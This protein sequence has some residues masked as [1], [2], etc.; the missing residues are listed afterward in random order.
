MAAYRRRCRRRMLELLT[1][2]HASSSSRA[3]LPTLTVCG[4]HNRAGAS[5]TS[6]DGIVT[7]LRR[8]P[9]PTLVA[10]DAERASEANMRGNPTLRG[11]LLPTLTAESY[12]S[13][14]GGSAG[15]EG[16]PD[17]PSLETLAK[18]LPTLT[19]SSADRGKAARGGNA[20]GGPSLVEKLLP[21]LCARDEKGIG[22]NHT[23][24]GQDLPRTLGGHLSASWCR[25]FMGFPAGWLDAF[26]APLFAR[27]DSRSFLSAPRSSD[28]SC[29]SS[30]A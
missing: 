16:Q 25:W 11:A 6:G 21:T 8:M 2:E 20:Q 18:R 28:G 29:E 7:A 17:R 23:K 24:G 19:A 14:R 12:G 22:P 26:V 1:L 27:S 10:G 5:P 4:N 15:R 3:V 13:N 9:L 30:K